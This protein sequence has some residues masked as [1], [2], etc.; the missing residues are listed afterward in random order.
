MGNWTPSRTFPAAD[1]ILIFGNGA[2][3]TVVNNVPSETIGRLVVQ[4]NTSV[5]LSGSGSATLTIRGNAAADDLSIAAGSAL[6]LNS[7]SPVN[8]TVNNGASGIIFG[9]IELATTNRLTANSTNGIRF[10]SGSSCTTLANY[11][12]AALGQQA[13]QPAQYF[14]NQGQ[15]TPT[16]TETIRFSAQRHHQLW[17]LHPEVTRYGT[18]EQD[19]MPPEERMAISQSE[20]L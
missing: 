16:T 12:G 2:S 17:Y 9:S 8:V 14:S 6:L 15:P 5:S 1:D 18:Q 3:G 20:Q 11:S 7:T 4:A 10:K 13:L 19:L